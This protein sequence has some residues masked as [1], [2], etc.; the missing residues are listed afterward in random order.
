MSRISA[1]ITTR[2]ALIIALPALVFTALLLIPGLPG[3]IDSPAEVSPVPVAPS[4]ALASQPSGSADVEPGWW[5]QVQERI[6][7][8][9]YEFRMGDAG[10]QAPNRQQDLRVLMSAAGVCLEPRLTDG[11]QW[12]WSWRTRSWGRE[13]ARSLMASTVPSSEDT[14]A[15][16]RRDGLVEWY[17]NR[18]EGLEQGF[19][20]AASP[21]G[22]GRLCIEGEFGGGL[23]ARLDGDQAIEFL[24]DEGTLALRY[25][26]LLAWDA[27]GRE[28]PSEMTLADGSI[29]LLIDDSEAVYPI[30][31]DP[32]MS[33]PDW[34]WSPNEQYALAGASVATAGDVNG[35][36][37]SD[38]I[39]GV[40]SYNYCGGNSGAAFCFLGGPDGLAADYDWFDC[41]LWVNGFYGTSVS[42]AGDVNGD[43]Y[44][45]VIVGAP[46]R[47]TDPGGTGRAYIY[48][49]SADGLQHSI[50]WDLESDQLYSYVGD[51]VSYAGDVN[52]DGYDDVIVSEAA[53][54][55]GATHD[56]G[57]VHVY[58]G[59]PATMDLLT[60]FEGDA[61]NVTLGQCVAGAGDVN[62]DGY[63]DVIFSQ[64]SYVLPGSMHRVHVRYGAASGA[65]TTG[66][67]LI[68]PAE[69]VEFGWSIS[70]AG[71]VNGDGYADI[72]VGAPNMDNGGYFDAGQVYCFLGG[73]GGVEDT[74]AWT[75]TV[76]QSGAR[77]GQSVATAGDV[78]GDGYA[79]VILGA[80]LWSNGEVEEG[81]AWVFLGSNSGLADDYVWT[82]EGNQIEAEYG[83]CVATA[84]DVNGDGFSDIIVG[85]H[86]YDHDGLF[87]CGR[88]FVYHGGAYGPKETAGWFAVSGQ[89]ESRAGF[90]LAG[91]GDAN[92][93]GYSD[94]L[95][96]AP[97]YDQGQT[98]EGV[99]W[100]FMGGPLGL[101]YTPAWFAEGNQSEAHFGFA[102]DFAGDVNGD[103]L[104]DILIGSSW[105]DEGQFK[106]GG[107]FL[108]FSDA[109]GMPYGNPANADWAKYGDQIG[110]MFGL[111]ACGAGD[112]NGDGYGDIAVGAPYYDNGHTNEGA[113]YCFH[114][115]ATG[116]STEHDWFR[117]TGSA[118][119]GFGMRLDG[120]GDVNGDGY[121][122]LIVGASHYDHY[123]EDEGLAFIYVG[124]A[125]G[126]QT[127]APWWYGESNQEN[128]QFG[129]TVSTAGDVN[130]D[131]YSDWMV[132][133]PY[134]DFTLTDQGA[135]FIW[136][137]GPTAPASG[138]PD[139]AD[140]ACSYLDDHAHAGQCVSTAGDVN[141]DGYSDIIVG[142]PHGTPG[143]CAYIFYGSEGG[144]SASG[145]WMVSGDQAGGSFGSEVDC[146]GDVNG[147]GFSDVIVAADYYTWT[148][149]DEG[150]AWLFY[151]NGG[152]QNLRCPR[153]MQP[154]FSGQVAALG[155]S[156]E[157][158]AIG[159]Q[160]Y[161]R[162]AAG[163]T[164]VKGVYEVK[165]H[166][167]P[168]DGNV[169]HV[170]ASWSP[171][172]VPDA[173]GT[174]NELSTVVSG[175]A[176]DT[177]YKWRM[178]TKSQN[179]LFPT[180]IWMSI[181][182]NPR[183]HW[184]FRTADDGTPVDPTPPP[185]TLA[186]GN[187]PNPF[188][189]STTISYQ[190]AVSGP[191][192]L[193]VH[194]V[195]GRLI[196]V[197]LEANQE[198][199]SH[200]VIWDGCDGEGRPLSSGVYFAKIENGCHLASR[201][202]VLMK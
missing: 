5:A 44:D 125:T 81:R 25:D 182:D 77:F 76:D 126:L 138:T 130:G 34:E 97:W 144:V 62:G 137:G 98:D 141:G 194:D 29:R 6:S 26:H 200:D 162:S 111:S 45:D 2:Q 183:T 105:Y 3:M 47:A 175:L 27:E 180:T 49:G 104:D 15:E 146:A 191:T 120:V 187:Y 122:D 43:G 19:T 139:N 11:S 60:T 78:N 171:L 170:D 80:E 21:A 150:G 71:D 64:Y 79:D 24:T 39:V 142:V 177:A 23:S 4:Q 167:V 129:L 18:A 20:I 95:V 127:D 108:W 41:S 140:F 93:D 61:A 112:V 131:G 32:L 193:S 90:S 65:L 88:A 53:W 106:E 91:G 181:P 54:D 158:N 13:D 115:S 109:G 9:E 199:G 17:E 123:T 67:T 63:D 7:A 1:R 132:G 178:R 164:S 201:K 166:D 68:G 133:A 50:F 165:P 85:A 149:T 110:A 160:A 176:A 56:A 128:A 116:P 52:G 58:T 40:P 55:D 153:Q 96:S 152:R 38:V 117:D 73:G 10:L 185:S 121:S 99:V 145:F 173:W 118:D 74:A 196:R 51:H 33:T 190:L 114:G 184:D 35:D 143:G 174:W 48:L 135:A 155:R 86:L 28:L 36:G 157:Q 8:S 154:D 188:N 197:L 37:Y 148:A 75:Y 46:Q 72:L 186:I 69:N 103:G 156:E 151:G 113:V 195:R 119:S 124:S 189:P 169:S 161:G 159:L 89:E 57:R 198:A 82:R 168:F 83:D 100:L 94:V 87:D 163:R 59:G 192:R 147:D 101:S 134:Y 179:P 66:D 70:P 84:G 92:G 172:G 202:L 107:A 14:R 102:V 42:T 12:D 30:V 22:A 136:Y 16:F 31:V